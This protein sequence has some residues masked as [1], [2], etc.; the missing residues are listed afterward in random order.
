MT[1]K[2]VRRNIPAQRENQNDRF[3]VKY[4]DKN[5]FDILKVIIIR[6]KT[7]EEI[8]YEFDAN[9]LTDKDSIHFSTHIVNSRLEIIWDEFISEK[10]R[11][12]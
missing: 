6:M 12:L 7:G 9:D 1:T 8:I 5:V 3:R 11:L 4:G 10:A 2:T